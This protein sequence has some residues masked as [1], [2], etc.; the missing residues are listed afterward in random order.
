MLVEGAD[1][2]FAL[3]ELREAAH[4]VVQVAVLAHAARRVGLGGAESLMHQLRAEAGA[5]L[6]HDLAQPLPVAGIDLEEQVAQQLQRGFHLVVQRLEANGQPPDRPLR[7][8]GMAADSG[9][10]GDAARGGRGAPRDRSIVLPRGAELAKRG[11]VA[12]HEGPELRRQSDQVERQRQVVD[13]VGVHV[14]AQ[15]VHPAHVVH[16]RIDVR[17]LSRQVP[18]G[19]LR[20]PRE[21]LRAVGL[22]VAA[23]QRCRLLGDPLGI[24][25]GEAS[26]QRAHPFRE[27]G[28][29]PFLHLRIGTQADAQAVWIGKQP[30]ADHP[31]EELRIVAV[32]LPERLQM[33][34][35][36]QERQGVHA[37]DPRVQHPVQHVQRVH[38]LDLLVV[39]GGLLQGGVDLLR[40]H[41]VLG[42]VAQGGYD[43]V[44]EPL[45]AVG[46]AVLDAHGEGDLPSQRKRP[47]GD[48]VGAD[49]AVDDRLAQR[50]RLVAEQD[51]VEQVPLDP[52]IDVGG[53]GGQPA[54]KQVG[55]AVGGLART[56]RIGVVEVA[57]LGPA[58]LQ[59]QVDRRR[60]A[61][62]AGEPWA[63]EVQVVPRR[64]VAVQEEVGVARLVVVGVVAAK[65]LVREVRDRF[66]LPAGGAAVDG[67]RQQLAH[68]A[69]VQ[70]RQR[71]GVGPLHLV[72]DDAGHRQRPGRVVRFGGG[73]VVAFPLEGVLGEQRMEHRVEVHLGQVEQVL[74]GV[75]GHRVVGAVRRRHGVDEGGHAHLQHLEERL[76]HREA[77][78][79]GQHHVLQ[80][81]RQPGVVRRRRG[82]VDREQVLR[83]VAVD[84]QDA[85]AAGPVVDS[86]G[87]SAHLR[88]GVDGAD[89][90]AVDRLAGGVQCVGNGRHDERNHTRRPYP[91]AGTGSGPRFSLRSAGRCFGRSRRRTAADRRLRRS[92]RRS[93]R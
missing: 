59:A 46:L 40:G 57:R 55:L 1:D 9:R 47:R 44:R 32:A 25:V 16:G 29:G 43:Q 20:Q 18:H 54:Q 4:Q 91:N 73:Q 83:V 67:V 81:V 74:A 48:Q 60:G 69:A 56:D 58:R 34:A 28:V 80:D 10:G 88:Y 37:V 33:L 86:V 8:L 77:A 85:G 7:L 45:G 27:G 66:R 38:G 15:D 72:V 89:G 76:A 52:G 62:Q 13:A 61:G 68:G 87:A 12:R 65:G 53:V 19:K 41:P 49:A 3:V 23:L 30:F 84:V 17:D 42:D 79:A 39:V 93:G 51:R 63:E 92:R 11:R 22:A 78:G 2:L 71:A 36:P 14:V 6:H 24:P 26:A 50:C 64:D 70:P 35:Q 21:R 82:E 90:E 75:A 5:R 31:L